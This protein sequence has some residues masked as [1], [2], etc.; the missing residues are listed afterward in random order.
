MQTVGT[1][2]LV[3]AYLHMPVI[4]HIEAGQLEVVGIGAA[5][6][7]SSAGGPARSKNGAITLGPTLDT[8]FHFRSTSRAP[9]PG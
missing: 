4:A 9:E 2:R 3:R 1:I 7:L 6:H 8:K 5:G